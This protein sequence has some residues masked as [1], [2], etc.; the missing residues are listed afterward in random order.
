[1]AAVRK[2]IPSLQQ[3]KMCVIT[4]KYIIL[5][6]FLPFVKC[7]IWVSSHVSHEDVVDKSTTALCQLTP[8]KS[9][10]N[11]PS[12]FPW[13]TIF[14]PSCNPDL[15]IIRE[16][17]CW[18]SPLY[19][20]CLYPSIRLKASPESKNLLTCMRVTHHYQSAWSELHCWHTK[21]Q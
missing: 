13:L 12:L 10:L 4:L 9:I 19:L 2:L 18:A 14:S 11:V 8:R 20:C 1:M 5:G 3:Y 15:A 21:W 17:Q 6:G 16:Q 7:Q